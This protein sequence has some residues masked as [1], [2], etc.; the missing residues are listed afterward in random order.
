[1]PY[2]LRLRAE[3]LERR[4][5]ALGLAKKEGRW[6]HVSVFESRM[7]YHHTKAKYRR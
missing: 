4:G 1:M 5:K 2:H 7:M 3:S 6:A